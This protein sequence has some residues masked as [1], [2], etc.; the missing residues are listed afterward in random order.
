MKIHGNPID[1][2]SKF[3]QLLSLRYWNRLRVISQTFRSI[4][5][6]FR[7]IRQISEFVFFIAIGRR[8]ECKT[9][10]WLAVTDRKFF[11]TLLLSK[12]VLA[13]LVL[14]CLDATRSADNPC[15]YSGS[16]RFWLA[17]MRNTSVVFRQLTFSWKMKKNWFSNSFQ[18]D[19]KHV[20]MGGNG[21][22]IW[23]VHLNDTNPQSVQ[24][25]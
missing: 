20:I 11:M 4:D 17:N 24:P 18:N 9:I 15:R 6:R 22:Y 8:N 13:V 1:F 23:V 10:T 3:V 12:E 21:H 16:S 19:L 14:A 25:I 5:V 7:R 2:V